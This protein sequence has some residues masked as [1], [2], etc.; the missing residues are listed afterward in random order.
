MVVTIYDI[1]T[2]GFDHKE[3]DVISIGFLRCRDTDLAVMSSGI[4]YMHNKRYAKSSPDALAVHG[5]TDEFLSQYDDKF[6]DNLV[7]CFGL[8]HNSVVIGKNNI[9]FDDKF[10]N[11]MFAKYSQHLYNRLRI[12]RSIDVQSLF[13]PR[14][15]RISGCDSNRKMGTLG[16]YVSSLGFTQDDVTRMYN[17]LPTKDNEAV[18][19]HGALYDAVAT[20]IVAKDLL[21]RGELYV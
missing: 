19:Y 9:K 15:R 21:S 20:W 1:E 18:R 5:L 8:F 16:Q 12:Q 17:E 3:D 13:A 14:W 2:T 7:R 4:F 10:I 6:N 11:M